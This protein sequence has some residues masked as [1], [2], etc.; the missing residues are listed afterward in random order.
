MLE[1]LVEDA[2]KAPSADPT[3]A[4]YADAMARIVKT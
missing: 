2:P 1:E 3:I 4:A